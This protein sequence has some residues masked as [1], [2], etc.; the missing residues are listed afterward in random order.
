MI[1]R[2]SMTQPLTEINMQEFNSIANR[3][4]QLLK[5]VELETKDGPIEVDSISLKSSVKIIDKIGG[6]KVSKFTVVEKL[7][8]NNKSDYLL[9]Y[10]NLSN[11][12]TLLKPHTWERIIKQAADLNPE[13]MAFR[14]VLIKS[15]ILVK[16]DIDEIDYFLNRFDNVRSNLKTMAPILMITSKCNIKC[17]YCYEEGVKL[18]SMSDEVI[19]GIIKWIDKKIEKDNLNA[20]YPTLFGGEP[21]INPKKLFNLMDGINKVANNKGVHVNYSCSSNGVLLTDKLARELVSKGLNEIQ[22]SLDGP[23]KIHNIRRVGVN[24]YSNYNECLKGLITACEFIDTPTL[25]INFDRHNL[26][27]IPDLY[28]SL[29]KN[30]LHKK[31]E[32]KLEPIAMQFGNLSNIKYDNTYLLPPNSSELADSYNFLITEAELRGF[33]IQ[34]STS[35]TTPCMLVFKQG[36]AIDTKGN[37]FKCI[38]LLGRDEYKVGS[39]F[40]DLLL[41]EFENQMDIRTRLKQ[42]IEEKCPFIPVCGGGCPYEGLVRGNQFEDRFCIRTFLKIHHKNKHLNNIYKRTNINKKVKHEAFI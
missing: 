9:I 24:G 8:L 12:S 34:M 11:K 14:N 4:Q 7:D 23:E 19:N 35:H 15:G 28:D 10:N 30:D 36:F 21:L 2:A 22:I 40:S 13:Q 25:K 33:K 37:I 27:F 6:Y 29:V 39:I 1:R 18:H 41:S 20:I 38:S 42:C 32:V 16:N 17:T 3:I 31:I 26:N 5:I